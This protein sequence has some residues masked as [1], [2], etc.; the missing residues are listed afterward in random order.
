VI[1]Y[2]G[3]CDL[4]IRQVQ[5]TTQNSESIYFEKGISENEKIITKNQLLIYESLK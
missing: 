3:D 2:K 5:P 1:V 4:E